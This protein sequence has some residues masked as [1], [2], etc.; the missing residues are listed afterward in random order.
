MELLQDRCD[1]SEGGGS[2]DHAGSSNK[3]IP[4][5]VCER[6]RYSCSLSVPLP[7]PP[8]PLLDYLGGAQFISGLVV[9]LQQISIC[10]SWKNKRILMTFL[11]IYLVLV[12]RKWVSDG[13]TLKW[14]IFKPDFVQECCPGRSSSG[15]PTDSWRCLTS[16]DSRR[17]THWT[18]SPF[19]D[20][21]W[22]A[23]KLFFSVSLQHSHSVLEVV[24]IFYDISNIN[25]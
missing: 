5:R 11:T 19:K 4:Q 1:V 22:L 3:I 2:G 20:E 6:V 24:R 13:N 10:L 9:V 15:C 25:L 12:P 16:K 21:D 8:P 7:H 18:F 14:V 17:R 23:G